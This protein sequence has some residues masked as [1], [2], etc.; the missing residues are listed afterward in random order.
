MTLDLIS[1][2]TCDG[3]L[4]QMYIT[5]CNIQ[6]CIDIFFKIFRGRK[7]V[8]ILF[9]KSLRCLRQLMGDCTSLHNG[10]I[11]QRTR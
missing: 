8:T 3:N 9:V 1:C 6:T 10:I 4:V 5:I 11:E 2:Y 7:E